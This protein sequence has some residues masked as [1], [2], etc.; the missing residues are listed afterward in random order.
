MNHQPGNQT[1]SSISRRSFFRQILAGSIEQIEA[2]GQKIHFGGSAPEPAN[3][4]YLRP[5]GA[6]PASRFA[7]L[8][9][10]CRACL[11]AC[12]A[13]CIQMDPPQ[14][15]PDGESSPQRLPYIV[16]RDAACVICDDLACTHAC[17][18]GALFPLLTPSEIHM[19][20]AVADH[21]RC[22]RSTSPDDGTGEACQICVDQCPVGTNALDIDPSGRVRVGEACVGCGVCEW[23]CPTEPASIVIETA[24]DQ[25]ESSPS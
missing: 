21:K 8:C 18:T 14:A 19:G 10:G 9:G 12:P 2:A 5:P 22:L 11:C 25:R 24:P 17:P 7:D 15:V 16:A 23:V 13:Q 1:P 4:R 6:T 3:D 20:T